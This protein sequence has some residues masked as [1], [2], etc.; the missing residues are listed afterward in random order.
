MQDNSLPVLRRSLGI[1]DAPH[2]TQQQWATNHPTAV[3]KMTTV[4]SERDFANLKLAFNNLLHQGWAISV[5]KGQ[6]P[7]EQ[8]NQCLMLHYRHVVITVIMRFTVMFFC[9]QPW[10]LWH[11]Q[12]LN[13]APNEM[14][15]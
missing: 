6:C 3:H 5:L 1:E 15:S 10:T 4:D 2:L 8:A 12:C 7:T 9:S 11:Y 13:I 14:S